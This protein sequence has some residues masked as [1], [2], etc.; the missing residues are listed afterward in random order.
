MVT[1]PAYVGAQPV[2]CHGMAETVLAISRALNTRPQPRLRS[3]A[4]DGRN[5]VREFLGTKRVAAPTISGPPHPKIACWYAGTV[6]DGPP[7]PTR[8]RLVR[9]RR[10]DI[11]E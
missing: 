1:T 5:Y 10:P 7:A 6:D 8:V 11:V 2:P 4:S 3:A 9:G